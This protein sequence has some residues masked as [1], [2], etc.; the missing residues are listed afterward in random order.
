MLYYKIELDFDQPDRAICHCKNDYGL[1][2]TI[3]CRARMEEPPEKDFCFF[4]DPRE[5]MALTDMPAN[6]KGWFIISKKFKDAI[7]SGMNSTIQYFGVN[8]KCNDV[9]IPAEEY[10]IANILSSV[11]ALCLEASDY[12]VFQVPSLGRP[13]YS[14]RKY[15]IYSNKT[16]G[17]DIF[18][19]SGD[20]VIGIFC[21]EKV[22]ELCEQNKITGVAFV[23]IRQQENHA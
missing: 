9:G 21:S 10:Y 14:V 8:I 16:N 6:D 4:Y 2:T 7:T 15:G 1:E 5:G 22:K 20:H 11:D 23:P 3:F 13:V 19:L 12:S 17:L 18:K